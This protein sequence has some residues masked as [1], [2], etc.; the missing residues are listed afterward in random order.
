MGE[1]TETLEMTEILEAIS[2]ETTEIIGMEDLLMM[3]LML[4]SLAE[5]LTEDRDPTVN[6]A[7]QDPDTLPWKNVVINGATLGFASQIT[8]E[9][10]ATHHQADHRVV[11]LD[12]VVD[13]VV[14]VQAEV[15]QVPLL[16]VQDQ[17]RQVEV[18]LR[19]Q[20]KLL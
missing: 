11:T 20:E 4:T 16:L 6:P 19:Q 17:A 14:E 8:E 5:I 12:Q 3:D 9:G 1:V 2:T 7:N 15:L 13:Q 18:L 10:H